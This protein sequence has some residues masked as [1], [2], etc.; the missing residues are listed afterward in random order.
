VFA[1]VA[2][3]GNFGYAWIYQWNGQFYTEVKDK[4]HRTRREFG[5]GSDVNHLGR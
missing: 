1:T 3:S 2:G 5:I 4:E